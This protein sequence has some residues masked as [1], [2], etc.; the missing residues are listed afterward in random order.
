VRFTTWRAFERIFSNG[1]QQTR[2]IREIVFGQRG[3]I[4][5]S[6]L[7]TDPRTLPREST[8]SIMTNVQGDIRKTVGNTYG[9]R[10]RDANMALNTPKMNEAGP[11]IASPTLSRSS[12]G[13]RSSEV[14]YLLVSL[15]CPAF[16]PS[17]QETLPEHPPQAIP[18]E[19]FL[20]STVFRDER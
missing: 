19:H 13:G 10:T 20:A 11:I 3:R 4:R 7:T 12:A 5:Y 15:Q 18:V 6:Q 2:F 9:M 16:H 1:E 14:A 8:W 17:K